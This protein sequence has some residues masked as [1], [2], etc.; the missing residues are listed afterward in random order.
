MTPLRVA[1]T[2][3]AVIGAWTLISFVTAPFL[4]RL[5]AELDDIGQQPT[6]TPDPEFVRRLLGDDVELWEAE[7]EDK[8]QS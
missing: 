6:P 4:G 3:L 8:E 5:L 7:L 2:A 1:L